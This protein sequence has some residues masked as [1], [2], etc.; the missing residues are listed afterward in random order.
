MDI[1]WLRVTTRHRDH[2]YRNTLD[3]YSKR[4]CYDHW[5]LK[6]EIV[7]ITGSLGQESGSKMFFGKYSTLSNNPQ[8]GP[9]VPDANEKFVNRLHWFIIYFSHETTVHGVVY[10]AKKGLHILER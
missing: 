8:K 9:P 4:F 2:W 1:Y 3:A 10:L 7:I 6:P 5:T